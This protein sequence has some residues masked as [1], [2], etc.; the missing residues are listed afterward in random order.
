MQVIHKTFAPIIRGDQSIP[1]HLAPALLRRFSSSDGYEIEQNM[2]SSFRALK[3]LNQK[4]LFNKIVIGVVTNSDDRVPLILSSFGLNVSPVR[5]GTEIGTGA[6]SQK[7]YDIDFHCMSYDV[8]AEKPD[9]LI[10]DAAELMLAKI[11]SARDGRNADE[12][13]AEAQSWDKVY[14][15]DEYSKDVIGAM[16]AS[17]NAILFEA[18]SYDAAIPNIK[19]DTAVNLEAMFQK[20]PV[21]G[22]DSIKDLVM[23]LT[24]DWEAKKD[25]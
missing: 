8:G 21:V 13:K 4:R 6:I 14:V 19:D 16:N 25:M 22:V 18:Y 3:G 11:I 9:R 1:S 17:W 12:A 24:G 2:V 5:H 10:F 23:W 7:L 20:S 15:G